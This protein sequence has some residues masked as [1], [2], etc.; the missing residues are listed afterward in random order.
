MD[1]EPT[2]YNKRGDCIS[3]EQFMAPITRKP[4]NPLV[5]VVGSSGSGKDTIVDIACRLTE[6]NLRKVISY[7]TRP[8]RTGET[9]KHKHISASEFNRLQEFMVAKTKYNGFQYGALYSDVEKCD[10]YI[11]DP[12]GFASIDT[13]QLTR[14]YKVVQVVAEEETR[15]RRMRE[16]GDTERAIAQ[17]IEHDR[18][19]FPVPF[20]TSVHV[21][22]IQNDID[23]ETE[24]DACAIELL[25]IREGPDVY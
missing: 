21:E 4:A 5:F 18:T 7:T 11:I 9:G 14:P 13:T 17:R 20:T 1:G 15:A 23:S 10:F 22:I 8:R 12:D 24:L 3:A 6:P 2:Y 19:T 16:R 25:M